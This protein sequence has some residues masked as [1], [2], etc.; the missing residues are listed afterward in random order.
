MKAK[1]ISDSI[2]TVESGI[3]KPSSE[4]EFTSTE[5]SFLRNQNRVGPVDLT[6]KPIKKVIKKSDG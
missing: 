5:Y 3:I 4:G 6:K 1:N 2:L